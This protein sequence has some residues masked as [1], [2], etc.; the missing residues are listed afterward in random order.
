M[1]QAIP[2][3]IWVIV[4]LLAGLPVLPCCGQGSQPDFEVASIKLGGDVFSPKPQISPGRIV[5]TTQ[6]AYL[7]AYAYDLEFNR[8]SGAG[9]GVVYSLNA[10]FESGQS[11]D[12][13]RRMLQS[14]LQERFKLRFHRMTKDADGL[15]LIANKGA[16]KLKKSTERIDPECSRLG[17][18]GPSV[19][20]DGYVSASLMTAS[21]VRIKGC[22]TSLAQLSRTL[23]RVLGEPFWDQTGLQGKYNFEFSF[24][25][26]VGA[27]SQAEV[28]ALAT[29][30][31]ESLGL[32][33]HRQK[34]PVETLVIDHVERPSAD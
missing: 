9:L 19:A 24:S 18:N 12:D 1:L 13:V 29:A 21:T 14:L 15:A 11:E 33:L 34:G 22:A 3:C 6:F 30:L 28:P 31:Q 23:E 16:V 25:Q 17:A 5:W 26:E 10:T 8:V 7:V 27:D 2:K 4:V 20:H 32:S